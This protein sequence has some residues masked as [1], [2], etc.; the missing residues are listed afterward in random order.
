MKSI[1]GRKILSKLIKLEAR[2]KALNNR[3]KE[4][5]SLYEA[6]QEDIGRITRL[7]SNLESKRMQILLEMQEVL[8]D[9]MPAELIDAIEK[10]QSTGAT[11]DEELAKESL[12]H[13]ARKRGWGREVINQIRQHKLDIIEL[14]VAVAIRLVKESMGPY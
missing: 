13:L 1:G 10:I 2:A 12:E 6:G 9:E 11:G 8:G 3:L 5:D 14:I 7:K 4:L